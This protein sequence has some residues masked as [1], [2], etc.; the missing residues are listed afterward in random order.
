VQLGRVVALQAL[1]QEQTLSLLQVRERLA[2]LERGGSTV[3]NFFIQQA[4]GLAIGDQAVVQLEPELRPLVQQLLAR[5]ERLLNPPDYTPADR[6]AY[7]Q[8]VVRF[9]RFY[10]VHQYFG[11]REKDLDK[12]DAWLAQDER[13]LALLSALAGLGKSALLAQWVARLRESEEV[14]VVYHPISLRF[15]THRREDVLQSL[16]SQLVEVY[17][18]EPP[19]TTDV[20][21]LQ[22]RLI[23]LLLNPP[24]LKRPVLVIVDGLDELDTMPKEGLSLPVP[25][26]DIHLLISVRTADLEQSGDL[27]HWRA[28]CNWGSTPFRYLQLAPLSYAEVE[29]V[30]RQVPLRMKQGRRKQLVEKLRYLSQ[31]HPLVLNL[32]LQRLRDDEDTTVEGFLKETFEP[33]LW[34]YIEAF[35]VQLKERMEYD[36]DFLGLLSAAR[37][38]LLLEDLDALGLQASY[39]EL[40]KTVEYSRGLIIGDGERQGF[41]LS[42]PMIGYAYA[43]KHPASFDVYLDRFVAYGH[44]ALVK[45]VDG[46]LEHSEVPSYLLKYYA[47]HLLES[48]RDESDE[49]LFDLVCEEW[50]RAHLYKSKS[51]E[52]FLKDI[53]VVWRRAE[54][55]GKTLSCKGQD[56]KPDIARMISLQAKCALCSST[57]AEL[58]DRLPPRLPALLLRDGIWTRAQVYAHLN[59][60]PNSVNRIRALLG[61]LRLNDDLNPREREMVVRQVL[62]HLVELTHS[63]SEPLKGRFL[64]Q[65]FPHLTHSY[66]LERALQL[67]QNLRSTPWRV[68]LLGHLVHLMPSQKEQIG[69]L[70][71]ALSAYREITF[72]DDTRAMRPYVLDA[73]VSDTSVAVL[74]CALHSALVPSEEGQQE[75]EGWS[76]EKKGKFLKRLAEYVPPHAAREYFDTCFSLVNGSHRYVT[77]IVLA[78]APKFTP[79]DAAAVMVQLSEIESFGYL[80]PHP[81]SSLITAVVVLAYYCGESSVKRNVEQKVKHELEN[82]RRFTY[83]SKVYSIVAPLAKYVFE[84]YCDSTLAEM[85]LE[86]KVFPSQI[87]VSYSPLFC[88]LGPQSMRAVMEKFVLEE[89]TNSNWIAFEMS[90]SSNFFTRIAQQLT[91]HDLELAFDMVKDHMQ[92]G[93]LRA[94]PQI[95][96][97]YPDPS[98]KRLIEFALEFG[99]T[100][101][102]YDSQVVA[103][104]ALAPFMNSEQVQQLA[105][106]KDYYWDRG[107]VEWMLQ[108]EIADHLK[109]VVRE[110]MSRILSQKLKRVYTVEMAQSLAV[111]KTSENDKEKR[112]E[113]WDFLLRAAGQVTDLYQQ[114]QAIETL[115]WQSSIRKRQWR[116]KVRQKV[117]SQLYN[118]DVSLWPPPTLRYLTFFDRVRMTYTVFKESAYREDSSSFRCLVDSFGI[119]IQESTRLRKL[120][121]LVLVLVWWGVQIAPK[122]LTNLWE[123]RYFL[124]TIFHRKRTP[125]CEDYADSLDPRSSNPL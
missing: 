9:E 97:R 32:Y 39:D 16:V 52:S 93:C 25:A 69:V 117:K 106:F 57:V 113:T 80:S 53:D 124:R 56:A 54:Q 120:A 101:R 77:G 99:A 22:S 115:L 62:N 41:V 46:E 47:A 74:K 34:K 94:I 111:M 68:R 100:T 61:V 75:Q 18:E 108:E 67:V 35:E 84:N 21:S 63:D 98:K 76:H 92:W 12:L 51:Y 79:S 6:A 95:V 107:Y 23:S 17:G 50:M 83:D 118:T 33:G 26:A 27:A 60:I 104:K 8:A 64:L 125:E 11:G 73:L 15:E 122:W 102:K 14:D 2:Q 103:L 7:L 91:D 1:L 105:I 59:K 109:P 90:V 19:T 24:T 86:G 71:E 40:A 89:Q 112:R 121:K 37:G 58:C 30:V 4:Q 119:A 45:L 38:P 78:L 87:D 123:K 10:L 82:S 96:D 72:T 88:I 110:K 114:T 31:G 42:H 20:G 49:L 116:F 28:E 13:R 66:Q 36:P 5:M 44:T 43:E 81:C 3:Y 48:R 29:K 55:I 65:V 85:I 70:T